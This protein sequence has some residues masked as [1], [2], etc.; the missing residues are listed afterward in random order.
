MFYKGSLLLGSLLAFWGIF[1]AGHWRTVFAY[2]LRE[3]VNHT[4]FFSLEKRA[5][6]CNPYSSGGV[7]RKIL[8]NLMMVAVMV[9]LAGSAFTSTEMSAQQFKLLQ[10]AIPAKLDLLRAKLDQAG[11]KEL[12]LAYVMS[13][14]SKPALAVSS[15]ILAYQ[16]F[17]S[18]RSLG[19]L[20]G[21]AIENANNPLA[22]QR[23]RDSEFRKLLVSAPQ[24]QFG[25]EQTLATLDE[26]VEMRPA[27]LQSVVGL[28]KRMDPK[29]AATQAVRQ[30]VQEAAKQVPPKK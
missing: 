24:E 2:F 28:A 17:S 9:G 27:Q 14:K 13:V 16:D 11:G 8:L 1:R 20:M 6:F 22:M 18:K 19:I 30:A 5:F 15:A 29:F 4:P 10:K 12:T 7:M 23:L 26:L 3:I 21:A 25:V